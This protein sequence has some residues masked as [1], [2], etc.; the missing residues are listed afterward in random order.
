MPH[1]SRP[2]FFHLGAVTCREPFIMKFSSFYYHLI[3]H[4]IQNALFLDT[5]NL[6]SS[7][8]ARGRI[9]YPCKATGKVM[10]LNITLRVLVKGLNDLRFWPECWSRVPVSPSSLWLWFV[11]TVPKY[12]ILPHFR[13]VYLTDLG[14]SKLQ[15]GYQHI[16][17][18]LACDIVVKTG[19]PVANR[20]VMLKV[21]GLTIRWTF[22][23]RVT[24][25]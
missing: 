12:F 8:N 20:P 17:G 9:F 7:L 24:L 22:V 19:W 3:C 5:S 6:C 10:V 11:L 16:Y 23:S 13:M 21:P 15:C 4:I 2:R 1:P 14:L 18:L 25:L